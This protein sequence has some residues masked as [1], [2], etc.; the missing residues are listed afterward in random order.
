MFNYRNQSFGGNTSL[1]GQSRS[2]IYF[3]PHNCGF[4]NQ[5]FLH[6]LKKI[7]SGFK[8]AFHEPE[9]QLTTTTTLAVYRYHE[10]LK[11]LFYFSYFSDSPGIFNL[12]KSAGKGRL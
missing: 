1:S 9:K 11:T 10:N 4:R 8:L 12:F 3:V 2:H 5:L 7:K 6:R